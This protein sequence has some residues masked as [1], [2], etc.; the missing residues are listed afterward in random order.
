MSFV[1]PVDPSVR[2]RAPNG[3]LIAAQLLRHPILLGISVGLILSPRIRGM[4]HVSCRYLISVFYYIGRA[5]WCKS[6]E[7]TFS[8]NVNVAEGTPRLRPV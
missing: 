8:D 6:H 5:C 7:L 2:F 1:A 4:D 3:S